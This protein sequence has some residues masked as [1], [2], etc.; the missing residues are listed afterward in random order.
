MSTPT[1]AFVAANQPDTEEKVADR[2]N[3]WMAGLTDGTY[4]PAP[5]MSIA[6]GYINLAGFAALAD[7]L[8]QFRHVRLLLGIPQPAAAASASHDENDL[9]AALADHREWL[10]RERDLT[11]FTLEDEA[12][13][14]R[15]VDWL[16]ASDDVEGPTVEVRRYEQAFVHGKAFIAGHEAAAM[17]VVVGS[18]NLTAAGLWA[19]LEMNIASGDSGVVPEVHQWYE[20]LWADAAPYDLAELYERKDYD[21]HLIFMRMLHEL[22]GD[23]L[24]DDNETRSELGLTAFQ[25]DGVARA[26]R[27]LNEHGGV[28]IADEVG[29]GKTYIAGEL[30][31][32]ATVINRQRVLI[33]APAALRTS[34]WEPFLLRFGFTRRAIVK[35]YDQLRLDW[36]NDPEGTRRELEDY[37][38]VV[39][40]EAHNLRN[41]SSQRAR[42]VNAMLAGQHRRRVVLLTATPVNNS[43]MDLHALV[44]LFIRNDAEFAAQG[45]PSIRAY[46]KEAESRSADVEPSE[47]FDL[48]DQVVVRRT[49]KFVKDNYIGTTYTTGSGEQRTID[50][51]TPVVGRLDYDIE[52]DPQWSRLLEAMDEALGRPDLSPEQMATLM[53]SSWVETEPPAV[54]G[55]ELSLARYV[56]ARWLIDRD[57][58]DEARQVHNAGLLRSALLKRLESGPY[59]LANTLQVLIDA[60]ENFLEAWEAGFVLRGDAL[61]DWS[62]PDGEQF[63][64][65]ANEHN[66]RDS[67]APA[68]AEYENDLRDEVAAD[69]GHLRELHAL[70][71]R[72]DDDNDPKVDQLLARLRSIAEEARAPDPTGLSSRDRRKTLVFSTFA[73]TI[74]DVH[75]RV[76]AA[77]EAADPTDPLAVFKARIAPAVRG[78]K[79]GISQQGRATT[80][81]GFA[82]KTA[83]QLNDD[84]QPLS[85]D[86]Y[87]LLFAT[88]VLAEGVN[89]QQAGRIVNYDLPWNPMRIVQRHGRID[90]IGS[91]HKRV[92]LDVYFPVAQLDRLLGIQHRLRIKLAQANA[93]IGHGAVLPGVRA[94]EGINY[95]E[96]RIAAEIAK[97][98]EGRLPEDVGAI[99]GEAFRK[100]L[101]KHLGMESDRQRL[102]DL[103]WGSGSGFVHQS[104]PYG[105]GFVFCVRIGS[106][107]QAKV[108]FV[109]TDSSWKPITSD[110]RSNEWIM[111][112]GQE[113]P[114]VRHETLIALTTAQPPAEDTARVLPPEA[115]EAAFFAWQVARDDV[116]AERQWLSDPA[117]LQPQPPLAFRTAYEIVQKAGRFLSPQRQQELLGCFN[118]SPAAAVVSEV[119][120]IVRD[121][122]LSER[123][124][125]VA[126]DAAAKALGLEPP[127]TPQRFRAVDPEEVHLVCWMAVGEWNAV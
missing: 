32:A 18:S 43:L 100:I 82:P 99:S 24:D 79:D 41:F 5:T 17:P 13:A 11:A 68:A 117:N 30:I 92:F 112:D 107:S 52:Q 63:E 105:P 111:D 35:S 57:T 108:R 49:R 84:G 31:H 88:D 29:L 72:A 34:M 80:L 61:R 94:V 95:N 38:L 98:R 76:S 114:A 96:E 28:M 33:L 8:E 65:W 50:F 126:L 83:G 93:A 85:D 97:L 67:R 3:A 102:V 66:S 60:H 51:P 109:P 1:S 53:E 119:R 106:E 9:K 123:E 101:S 125:V 75:R 55:R 22:Y 78:S 115:F 120:E 118:T 54:F 122:R 91:E 81:A 74:D 116:V 59:A 56:P 47:L 58:S 121:E 10:A 86:R 39:I 124:M 19:N 6:T 4:Q 71:V 48:I 26:R 113:R 21:P 73:D 103:P 12:T 104:A 40:D 127:G 20:T 64:T 7:Q 27:K 44:S 16:R 110:L 25:L 42:V 77:V 15:L 87:D 90:R 69:L 2:L 36:D 37:S 46:V 89:L 70:A 45:I 14:R 62:G 23:S